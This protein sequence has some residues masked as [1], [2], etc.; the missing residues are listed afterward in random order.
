MSIC[1]C[2]CVAVS[3]A[4]LVSITMQVRY[5]W[6]SVGFVHHNLYLCVRQRFFGVIVNIFLE[7]GIVLDVLLLL[8]AGSEK[9]S[10]THTLMQVQIEREDRYLLDFGMQR[11]KQQQQ[12]RRSLALSL[13]LV[14]EE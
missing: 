4:F 6:L 7:T 10:H 3:I 12:M 13:I 9:R 14:S 1:W 5:C 8:L 2:V 11:L